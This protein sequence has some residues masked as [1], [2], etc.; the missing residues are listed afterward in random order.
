MKI[1]KNVPLA[2]ETTFLCGGNAKWFCEANNISEFC[3]LLKWHTGKMYILGGGSKTLCVD[4]GFDG[5]VISTKKLDKIEMV[6][7]TTIVCDCGVRF[8][9]LHK[10]CIEN[11]FGGLEWSAGIPA[12]VG[13]AVVMNAGAFGHDFSESV[14]QVEIFKNN[15]T[16]ILKK[17]EITFSYRN[18]SLKG[19]NVLRVWLKLTP[20]QKSEIEK[21]YNFY[22]EQKT[23]HQPVCVG[24]AG[25]VFK[26]Q[27]NVIPAKIIDKLGL[28]GV[29]IGG[30]EISSQH[31][32]FIVNTGTAKASDVIA[33]VDL[34][35]TEV[36]KHCG[37]SL[38][39]ELIIL[40]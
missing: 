40:E 3:N 17:D 18:S 26:R 13:G 39:K 30:A 4:E 31:S 5:L 1:L 23:S 2:K 32:G 7:D 27:K 14:L 19:Q 37:I 6:E 36:K 38:E 29:K 25:S 16:K 10:F 15:T 9:D 35:L 12:S 8:D 33:L 11:G 28:K 21:K 20:S 22:L 34:I 24:S